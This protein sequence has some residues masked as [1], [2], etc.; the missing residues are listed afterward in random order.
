VVVVMVALA[1]A[2]Q[3]FGAQPQPL[4]LTARVI[5]HGELA[6]FGPFEPAHVQTLTTPTSF[7]AAYQQAATRAQVTAW[8]LC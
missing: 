3:G 1:A 8:A 6:G 5:A 7:L 2:E 4:P